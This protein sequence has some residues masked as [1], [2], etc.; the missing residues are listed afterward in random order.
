M[1]NDRFVAVINARALRRL[2]SLHGW[3]ASLPTAVMWVC[4]HGA[5]SRDPRNTRKLARRVLGADAMTEA[6]VFSPVTG[7]TNEREFNGTGAAIILVFR[8]ALI[9][10]SFI[11]VL[12]CSARNGRLWL[13]LMKDTRDTLWC[14]LELFLESF[15]KS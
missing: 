3:A 4:S 14:L 8:T 10:S 5:C 13:G 11:A 7:Q 9:G 12:V 1:K 6:G 15:A 2:Q